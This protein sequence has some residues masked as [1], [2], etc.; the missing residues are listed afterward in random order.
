[1]KIKV[2]LL[3]DEA[4]AIEE[5]KSMLN[6]YDFIEVVATFTNPQE[7]LDKLPDMEV[8]LVFLDIHMPDMSGFD[9][10]EKLDHSPEVI[11]VTAYDQ[12][13]LRAFEVS[14]LDYILK[15]V[16]TERLSE[17]L[18]RVKKRL[19]PDAVEDSKLSIEKRI[20]IK[21]GEQCFFV[22]LSD[23][24]LLESVGNYVRV[25]YQDKKPLLHKSLNYMEERLPEEFFFRANRQ[26][27]I[28]VN[29]IAN[30][31]P[32]FNSTLQLELRSGIKIDISQRQSVRFKDKMSV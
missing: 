16:N 30:I 18:E 23:I 32:Y 24:F 17:A 26:H 29:Y 31:N 22:P 28:N 2:A 6:V 7:A 11:F 15:P 8:N 21:D 20:F 12:F 13:A 25:H 1:M 14:A 9:W 19:S 27:I 10:L 3:D 5:L 4:L